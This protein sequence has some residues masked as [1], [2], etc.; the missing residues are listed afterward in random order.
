M[1]PDSA[2]LSSLLRSFLYKASKPPKDLYLSKISMFSI[3]RVTEWT[4][5]EGR[6]GS[7]AIG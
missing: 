6:N 2:V 7:K 3:W 5:P 4:R 1:E